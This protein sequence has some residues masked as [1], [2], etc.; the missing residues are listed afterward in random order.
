MRSRVTCPRVLNQTRL[1]TVAGAVLMVALAAHY[2]HA[3]GPP[4]GPLRKCPADAVIA[5]TVCM[6]KYEA[7][8]WQVPATSPSGG[9][10]KGIQKGTATLANLQ[11]GGATQISP[12]TSCSPAFPAAGSPHKRGAGSPDK[13]GA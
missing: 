9:S 4:S 13:R 10:N 11:A 1:C 5:G 2:A 12:S 3:A 7:S 6:D 8:V